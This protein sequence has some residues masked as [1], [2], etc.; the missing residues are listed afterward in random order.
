MASPHYWMHRA[1]K[2]VTLLEAEPA[3][4]QDH[5]QVCLSTPPS[6]DS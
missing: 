2:P 5:P 6:W 3:P 4:A 1:Q